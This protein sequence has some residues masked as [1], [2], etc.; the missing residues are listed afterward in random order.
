MVG[1]K[2]EVPLKKTTYVPLLPAPRPAGR[3]NQGCGR[4]TYASCKQI[5]VNID[6]DTIIISTVI[7]IS[8]ITF[9]SLRK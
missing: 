2:G 8:I 7:N 3:D 6:I 9:I 1:G 5:V 4:G